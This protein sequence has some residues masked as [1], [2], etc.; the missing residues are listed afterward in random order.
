MSCSARLARLLFSGA[1]ILLSGALAGSGCRREAPP[2]R[3]GPVPG[4]IGALQSALAART[5]PEA[6]EGKGSVHLS[7]HDEDLPAL[8]ARFLISALH[9]GRVALRPGILPPVLGLWFDS[10]GWSLRLPRQRLACESRGEGPI[11]PQ[12][13]MRLGRYLFQPQSLVE[14]LVA[15]RR[16]D[17][18][19]EWV[20]RG[21]LRQLSEEMDVAE[22]WI[23]PR[24][25]GVSHWG[26]AARNGETLL[27]VA[28]EPPL[29]D[30]DYRGLIRI[31]LPGLGLRGQLGVRELKQ[32]EPTLKPV[33]LLP[34]GWDVLSPEE[35]PDLLGG[36]ADRE[37]QRGRESRPEAAR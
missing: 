31:V 33:P 24:T 7:L 27:R 22:I 3:L 26:L 35:L 21:R 2:P 29:E 10:Q 32:G 30:A 18:G 20:L 17:R 9:G 1:L 16:I 36:F 25:L 14:D 6:L 8:D 5:P 4:D 19:A 11:A 23:D 28:Y 34:A 12:S 37:G 13:M 15:P